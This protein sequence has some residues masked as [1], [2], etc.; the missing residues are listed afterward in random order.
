MKNVEK[1]KENKQSAGFGRRV[2]AAALS[3]AM[4]FG[5]AGCGGDNAA[6]GQ[7]GEG[8]SPEETAAAVRVARVERQDLARTITLGGLLAPQD[9]VTILGGGSGSKILKINVAVGDKVRKG[10]SLMT[11][12]MKDIQIQENNLLL[13]KSQLEDT[14]EKNKALYEVGAVAESQIT[15]L[16]NQLEQLNLQLETIELTKEKMA[17]TATIDG[18]V[19][20][21]PV[22]EG[23]MAAASTVVASIVNID[24]LLLD[25]S[26]GESYIMGIEKGDELEVFIPAYGE[27]PVAGR[28]K[29]VPPTINPQTRAYTVT[30]EI[31]NPEHNIKGGMYAEIK[32]T[33]EKKENT[34]VIPQQAILEIDGV[35]SAFIV[36][37]GSAELRQVE[38]GLTLGDYAEVLTGL[39]EGES[40]VVEGQYTLSDGRK[41]E[42]VDPD[43]GAAGNEA[44]AGEDAADSAGAA[45]AAGAD[46]GDSAA[47]GESQ[48]EA[49]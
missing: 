2:A 49:Q 8:A 16:E 15:S 11:Q 46:A 48:G 30:I 36:E 47:G 43:S 41:V 39:N 22:V 24:Q 14:Y 9:E 42:V 23:Q 44:A 31:D 1:T 10:Q 3:C 29:S 5:L 38:T 12:D 27:Q 13:S 32:L 6:A 28:V 7:T 20:A 45:D 21:L 4:L 34:L 17:V 19:S 18:I 25:V 35:P 37:G 33:V 40:V 26:V